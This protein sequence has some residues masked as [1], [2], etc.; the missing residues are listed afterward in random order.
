MSVGKFLIQ[1]N[2]Y[3]SFNNLVQQQLSFDIKKGWMHFWCLNFFFANTWKNGW[4]MRWTPTIHTQ[5]KSISGTFDIHFKSWS[6]TISYVGYVK[7]F[8]YKLIYF[9]RM[10]I[11][12]YDDNIDV[13]YTCHRIDLMHFG[14]TKSYTK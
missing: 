14:L 2:S 4:C 11:T 13:N 5:L 7:R 10:P 1:S 3:F 12:D 8:E 9:S 6:I